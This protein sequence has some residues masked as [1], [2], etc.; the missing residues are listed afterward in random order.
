MEIF[1]EI[2]A[3]MVFLIECILCHIWKA[4]QVSHVPIKILM[5][6]TELSQR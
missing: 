1:Y 2:M 3:F 6:G 4:D 5:L